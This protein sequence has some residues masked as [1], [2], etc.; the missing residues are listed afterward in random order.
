MG[1]TWLE[2]SR[3]FSFLHQFIKQ[4]KKPG[5]DLFNQQTQRTNFVRVKTVCKIDITLH[6]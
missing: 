4:K 2:L 3:F 1:K 6:K 5:G